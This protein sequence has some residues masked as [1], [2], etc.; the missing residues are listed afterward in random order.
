M[1]EQ[2]TDAAVARARLRLLAAEF[3]TPRATRRAAAGRRTPT[4]APREPI[5]LDILDHLTKSTREIVDYTREVVPDADPPP[6][7]AEGIY[8][9]MVKLTPHLD[10][11]RQMV[12]DAIIHRQALEHAI[13]MGDKDVI[14]YEECPGC[15]CWSLFWRYGEDQAAC[16]NRYCADQLG[17][18]SLWT[19][20]QIAEHYVDVKYAARKA[21][22]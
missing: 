15:T 13:A 18:P 22:T 6:A 3:T 9:W 11:D 21:A 4:T 2:E 20:Q 5:N 1:G 7:T 19:L 12:R 8:G 16:V 14:R 17:R 10:V